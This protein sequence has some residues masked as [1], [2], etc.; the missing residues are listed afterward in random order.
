MKIHRVYALILRH[1]YNLQRSFDRLSDVFYWPTIDL[2]LWGLAGSYFASLSPNS[3]IYITT[4][5]GSILLWIVVW[6][7]QNEITINILAELWDKNLVNIFVSPLKL[8]EWIT[9]LLI[10]GFLKS[11]VSISFASLVAFF[12]YK[13]NI[14]SYGLYLIPFISLLLMSGWWVGFLVAAIII[15]FGSRIQTLAWTVPWAV[16]PFSAIYFPVAILP[17]WAQFISR[18]LPSSYI[19]EGGRQVILEHTL[20]WSFVFI[21]FALNLL[22]LVI[23]IFIFRWSFR[24]AMDRGL[25]GLN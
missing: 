1:F 7:A 3:H 21:S 22:Y 16:A 8:S 6:R 9:S 12:L 25:Q 15:R 24:K 10:M 4:V 2:I 13:I 14:L 17:H 23:A 19:F 5:I 11:I 18:G 20:N